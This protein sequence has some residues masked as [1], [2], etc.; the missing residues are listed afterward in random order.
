MHSLLSNDEYM[1]FNYYFSV[2]IVLLLGAIVAGEPGSDEPNN[3]KSL[4][5]SLRPGHRTLTSTGQSSIAESGPCDKYN[6]PGS[7]A[8]ILCTQLRTYFRARS[9]G[10]KGNVFVHHGADSICGTID[11]INDPAAVSDI[12]KTAGTRLNDPG[13]RASEGKWQ[14]MCVHACIQNIASVLKD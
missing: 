9:N 11:K 5:S 12:I 14:Y 8:S 6:P 10:R 7:D 4:E 1:E 2:S 3:A 13:L